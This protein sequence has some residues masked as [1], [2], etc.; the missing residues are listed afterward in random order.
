MS[1]A[2]P[3]P[4]DASPDASPHDGPVPDGLHFHRVTKRFGGTLALDGVTLSVARGEIVALLGENGAGKSTLIKILGGIHAPDSGHV[5]IDRT[6]YRHQPGNARVRQPVA[7]IH[8]DLGLVEWMSIAENMAMA[9]GYRRRGPFIDWRACERATRDALERIDCELEPTAR[10]ARLTRAEKS[11]VAIARA[12]AVDCDYL[13]LDEPTASLPS[14]DVR[15]LFEVLRRLR[16]DGVGMIYVSH[17]LDEVFRISDRVVVLR[18]GRTVGTRDVVDTTPGELVDLIVGRKPRSFD[19]L[20]GSDATPVLSLTDV[21]TAQAGPVS[22][23]VREGEI[24]ALVGLRGAGQ[25]SVGRCL[26]G[27]EDHAGGMALHGRPYAP[28]SPGEAMAAGVGLIPRDRV[29]ES[30]A[31]G[32]SIR[33]NLF[34]NP[35]TSGRGPLAFLPAAA[36]RA[37]AR[38]VGRT[39]GLRPNDPELPIENL[40]GGNQQKVVVGRWLGANMRLLIAEDPTAGVDVGAKADIYTLLNDTVAGGVAVLVISTDFEEVATLCSRALVFE[41]GLIV[42]EL[43]GDALTTEALVQ[44]A[45]AGRHRQGG[46]G[47]LGGLGGAG[48]VGTADSTGNAA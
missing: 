32:L 17:R 23:D 42:D 16:A 8:Q 19:R 36:E 44:A 40:S 41:N 4:P 30:V 12:L 34:V 5:V 7:F 9:Q 35:G 39:V 26:F 10:V 29:V 3:F 11:L 25:E 24:L 31:T 2:S 45:S 28:G 6:P 13:V 27:A 48:A 15:Q 47:G 38:E 20:A 21:R 46:L 37:R 33:E 1:S 22:L 43:V 14:E 18:D